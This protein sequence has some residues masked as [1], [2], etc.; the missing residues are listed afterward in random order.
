MVCSAGDIKF[1]MVA[2]LHNIGALHSQLGAADNRMSAEGLKMSCTH[3]QCAAW[4]FQVRYIL[5]FY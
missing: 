5:I 3:F 4:A 1:E 2:I